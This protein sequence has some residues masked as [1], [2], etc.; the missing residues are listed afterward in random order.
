ME[1]RIA[2]LQKQLV[3]ERLDGIIIS[4]LNNIRYLCGYTGSNGMMIVTRRAAVF[5]TDFRY[6]EQIKT[7]VRGCDKKILER[8]LYSSFPVAELKRMLGSKPSP[9]IG[10]E[11]GN[12]SLARFRMLR[13]Q[14]KGV[15]LIPVRDLVLELRRSKSRPELARMQRAQEITEQAFNRALKL[16]KP[17]I[18]EQDL[19]LEIEFYF[20]RFGEPAFPSIVASGENGAKPH[21]RAGLRRLKK[22]D[23]ITFDIGCRYQGYCADMTRTVFLGRPDPELRR[24]YEA[25]LQAQQEALG[26][27]KP[28]VPCK[29]VDLA[30][31]E[32]LNQQQ[33]GQFFG[34]SLGHGVGLEVH[35]QP[36]LARTS[37]QTL[38][39]GD[40]VTVEPGVYLP[41]KGGVRI[42][43]MV[44]VTS[45][46]IRN[47]TK[48]DKELIII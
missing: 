8:D 4:G 32:Y 33:L 2:Q 39:P 12:L 19:A 35:E 31:R 21:A 20:R 10:V 38:E 9:R 48:A 26:V 13:R 34:H 7:E 3:R 36:A 22:G 11:E 23:A 45:T 16:V 42:E 18:T 40:V 25:V 15:R 27:M 44:L 5:Y 29:F 6:Q 47:F 1:K 28:G 41:G 14:L 37:R 43:D 30:A 46:G 24:I 17:G